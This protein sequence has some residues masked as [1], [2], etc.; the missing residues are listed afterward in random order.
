MAA[1]EQRSFAGG[2]PESVLD[3]HI[4]SGALSF[5]IRAGDGVNY[6]DGSGGP[7]YVIIGFDTSSAE[8]IRCTARVGDTF[9]VPASGGRGVDGTTAT[10][11]DAN[12]KVRHCVTATDLAE[13]NKAVVNT[14]GKV[15]TKGDLLVATAAN[16]LARLGIGANG[17]VPVADSAQTTGLKWAALAIADIVGL[18]AAL[19]AKADDTDIAAIE[20]A[21]TA[22]TPTVTAVSSPTV[23]AAYK[24]IGKTLFL[25]VTFTGG[26]SNAAGPATITVSLPA[27][28]TAVAGSGKQTSVGKLGSSPTMAWY[29]ADGATVLTSAAQ[30]PTATPM[31]GSGFSGV[32]EVA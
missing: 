11:H 28:L 4:T 30:A 5:T 26:T 19:D 3:A 1:Y 6:P 10:E 17:Q 13:A 8:K 29:L 25:R 2:A 20:A 9:T 7:F 18:T 24:L 16:V 12:A 21:W 14:V 22:Y 27:G 31:A 15:T 32:F 23:E